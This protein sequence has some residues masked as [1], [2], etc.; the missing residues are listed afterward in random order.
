M[1][2]ET[3]HVLKGHENSV[4]GVKILD[5]EKHIY[6]TCS[7]DK[8]IRKWVEGK[9][10]KKIIAHE[11]AIRDLAVLPNGT[12]ASCSND[13]LIK[14]WD[15]ETFELIKILVGHEN[16]V[17]SLDVLPNGDLIS[18]GEDRTVRIWKNAED[19]IQVI[20][21]PCLSV[22]KAI[23][24][25][26]GDIA[27]GSSDNKV[28]VFTTN[29]H[30]IAS[31]D[32]IK[33]FEDELK[34]SSISESAIDGFSKA[35]LPTEEVLKQPGTIEGQTQTVKTNLGTIE[36]HK[37]ENKKWVKIGE[38][39][40]SAT[41]S[42]NEKKFHKGSW[43][44]YVFNVDIEDGKP[45]LKLPFNV[46]QNPYDVADKFLVDN[47]LP[48]S[49]LQQIVDF[50]MKNSE[51]VALDGAQGASSEP[52]QDPSYS[53]KFTS[54]YSHTTTNQVGIL[55]QTQYL[56]F[57]KF[58]VP[59]LIAGFKKLNA[60]QKPEHQLDASHFESLI[61][62]ED[63]QKLANEYAGYIIEHWDPSTK[64]IGFDLLRALITKIKPFDNLFELVRQGLDSE[65]RKIKMMTIRLLVNIFSCRSW[66][67]QIFRELE[68]VSIVFAD[69]VLAESVKL[70]KFMP[71]I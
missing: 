59:S 26:N 70:P 33:L 45:P 53:R 39:V 38:I 22:W 52:Y 44:D 9:E 14:I 49:Y 20:S 51:G 65:N 24:L 55:P 5:A 3:L 17:Y 50:I 18:S 15:L 42:S 27:V 57:S 6:L 63:Y 41:S 4:W 32:E 54:G 58:D 69:Q 10:V 19:C 35:A 11:D 56:T 68:V 1:N 40:S 67:E 30:R 60:K 7:A 16:F 46:S 28:R 71:I 43:Y 36:I 12:F 25:A 66:G 64:L 34:T 13:K 21:L 61:N 47:K 31:H 29:E 37:W 48:Y 23:G 62:C 2:G 8:T